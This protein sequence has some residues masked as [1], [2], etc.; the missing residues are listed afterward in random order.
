MAL[1]IAIG[2]AALTAAVLFALLHTGLAGV[3]ALDLP[4]ERSLHS[5]AVPRSGGLAIVVVAMLP[6]LWLG[7]QAR[8]LGVMALLLMAVS[9]ID[10]RLGLPV[11]V[12]L[13]AHSIVSITAVL[14]IHGASPFWIAALLV[15]VIVWSINAYNFMDGSDGMAG[16][17][18]VIGFGAYALGA[19]QGEHNSLAMVATAI[20]GSALGFLAFNFPPARLFMGDS[21]S[22]PLGFLAGTLGVL[23]WQGGA[24]TGWFPVLV[25]STFLV[26]ASMTLGYRLARGE[27]VWVAHKEHLYQRMVAGGVGHTRTA[28]VAYGVMTASAGLALALEHAREGTAIVT[29]I[30]LAGCAFLHHYWI[31]RLNR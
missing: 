4:N 16:G 29:M 3:L 12:R 1:T 18:A 8:M 28:L 17:M 21:G 20:A 31:R 23:G 26:D 25:F 22:A 15:V 24:W 10:D 5:R 14:L 2:C 27:R 9:A 11:V 7:G 13:I 30:W 19:A 6:A